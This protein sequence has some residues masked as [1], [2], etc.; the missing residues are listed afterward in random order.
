MSDVATEMRSTPTVSTAGEHCS[1]TTE[2]PLSRLMEGDEPKVSIRFGSND[3]AGM[4]SGAVALAPLPG[5]CGKPVVV[6]SGN[7]SVV[8]QWTAPPR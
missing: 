7:D 1:K 3:S 6:G 5:V 8:V 4:A 2:N